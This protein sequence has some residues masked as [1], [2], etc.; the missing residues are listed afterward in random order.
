MADFISGFWNLYVAGLVAF[1]LVFCLV[2]LIANMTAR[3]SGEPKLQGHVWDETLR[4]YNNPLPRWWLYLFWGTVLFAI[5]Y[6]VLFPGFGAHND[7]KGLRAEYDAEVAKAN[8][9]YGPLFAKY[10][11]T[12]LAALA[13]DPEAVATGKRL[14]LTYCSQCHG[15]TA[16]GA[17]G[18]DYGFPNLTDNDWLYGGSPATIKESIEGG[19]AGV[20]TAF[21]GVLN[22][23]QIKDV[24]NY[25]RSLSGLS[26]DSTRLAR[27][28]D[29][30]AE[31]CAVCHGPNGKGAA[32]MGP[33][34]AAL[35]APD[36]TDNVW[37][38]SN[39]EAS[40]IDGVTRGRNA[41]PGSVTNTMPAWKDF[42]GDAKVHILAAYVYSLSKK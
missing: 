17:R 26:A 5:V 37:L 1:G 38:Y 21:G 33:D 12:D 10:Q 7:G 8:D 27:G 35:G 25:V 20:M 42:L 36:L 22:S 11:G 2:V 15:S 19:R 9:T 14:F 29:V 28:K 13:S 32:S 41:G 16:T 24:A 18:K 6:L 23:D 40:I 34:F 39:S 4:E 30:F 3:E 31:N